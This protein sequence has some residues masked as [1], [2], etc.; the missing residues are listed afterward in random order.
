MLKIACPGLIRA[1]SCS[2][3][4]VYCAGAI[5]EKIFIWQESFFFVVVVIFCLFVFCCFFGNIENY[6]SSL[7]M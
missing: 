5:S 7:T 1:L 6:T 2:P 3:N 4:G